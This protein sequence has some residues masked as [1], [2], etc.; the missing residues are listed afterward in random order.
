MPMKHSCQPSRNVRDSPGIIRSVPSRNGSVN[1]LLC[2]PEASEEFA[3]TTLTFTSM[4]LGK[5]EDLFTYH[6]SSTSYK[7]TERLEYAC[8]FI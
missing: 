7:L 1:C 5:A 8:I 3:P 4:N 2:V 6:E